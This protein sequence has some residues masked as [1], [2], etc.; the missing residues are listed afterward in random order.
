MKI[1]KSGDTVKFRFRLDG[2]EIRR[3]V[4]MQELVDFLVGKNRQ[5]SNL[6][7]D[8]FPVKFKLEPPV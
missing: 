5:E 6:P 8:K 4:S 1:E 7:D 3:I 2:E